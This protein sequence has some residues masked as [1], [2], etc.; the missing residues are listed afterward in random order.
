MA[1][2]NTRVESESQ[3]PQTSRRLTRSVLF[4]GILIGIGIAGFLDE[5]L[6]HQLLQWHAFY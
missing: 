5:T 3:E 6:F 2:P 4:T 1:T